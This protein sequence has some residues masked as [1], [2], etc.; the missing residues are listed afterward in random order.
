MGS[1]AGLMGGMPAQMGE[2]GAA[3]E[4][5]GE[6]HQANAASLAGDPDWA[7]E[8][9]IRVGKKL[10][11]AVS[12]A[13]DLV[14]VQQAWQS[15]QGEGFEA[16]VAG[17]AAESGAEIEAGEMGLVM[18]QLKKGRSTAIIKDVKVL[19]CRIPGAPGDAA[20]KL[21]LS[22]EGNIPLVMGEEGLGFELAPLLTIRSRWENA[23]LPTFTPMGEEIVVPL[24]RFEA[25][26]AFSLDVEVTNQDDP[27]AVTLSFEPLG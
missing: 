1:L 12:A 14:K 9:E 13:L 5:F 25:G 27:L 19:A 6:Q 18:E 17:V 26:K 8:A 11:V 10:H 24:Q 16:L 20:D 4:G 2:L 23:D 3:L 21:Q 22:P 15:T 7:L